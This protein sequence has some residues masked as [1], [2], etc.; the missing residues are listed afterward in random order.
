M[1]GLVGIVLVSE[2]ARL[3]RGL[4]DLAGQVAGPDVRIEPSG[5]TGEH[6]AGA[7]ARAD[8]GAG[9]LVLADL[10]V[11]IH[12]ARAVLDRRGD[13]AVRLADAPLVEGAVAA[14]VTAAIGQPL[15]DVARA[16]E[17]AHDARKR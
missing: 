7:I 9:V 5:A 8:A 4:A 2:S 6:V 12:A 11:A 15:D 1:Q 14:A 10:D 13:G 3:A 16:A 17:E